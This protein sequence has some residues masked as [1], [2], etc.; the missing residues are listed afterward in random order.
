MKRIPLFI[1]AFLLITSFAY[2]LPPIPAP[3][4]SGLESTVSVSANAATC[5]FATE[6]TCVITMQNAATAWT[7]TMSNPT[8]GQVYRM[9]FIQNASGGASAAPLPTFSP[10]V[11]WAGGTAP[12][13][14]TTANK[15]D[16]VTCYYSAALSAYLCDIAQ[17]F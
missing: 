14:T 10:T 6:H 13:L 16:I 9:W 5:N 12:T 7:L 3:A 1:I 15:R 2:A 11:T 4:L 8:S 17:N